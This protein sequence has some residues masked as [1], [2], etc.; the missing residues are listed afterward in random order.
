M[1]I[2][3]LEFFEIE[4]AE[5]GAAHE[6]VHLRAA[7]GRGRDLVAIHG[8]AEHRRL[9]QAAD[10]RFE[11]GGRHVGIDRRAARAAT[12]SRD[13]DATAVGSLDRVVRAR[14]G[15]F[16]LAAHECTAR[17]RRIEHRDFGRVSIAAVEACR[18]GAAHRGLGKHRGLIESI[19]HVDMHLIDRASANRIVRMV[20]NFG[21][22]RHLEESVEAG[23]AS[24]RVGK[25]GKRI[26]VTLERAA[27][28]KV[29]LLD[30][31]ARRGDSRQ[32][33][34]PQRRA[35]FAAMARRAVERKI[36]QLGARS[37]R[38]S[39]SRTSSRKS[40]APR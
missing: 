33:M 29:A 31:G 6:K 24:E 2:A 20:L 22:P 30:P 28:L 21:A 18:G 14:V 19:A 1:R 37:S 25:R 26:G 3:C 36:G 35:Q 8:A 11:F 10:D 17:E 12:S 13:R 34:R 4:I 32:Q 15:N 39:R 7:V 27:I 5:R 9:A 40:R 38:A 16:S 23:A